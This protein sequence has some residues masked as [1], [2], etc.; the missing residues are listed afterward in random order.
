M[1]FFF[2]V[3]NLTNK[4]KQNKCARKCLFFKLST[5]TQSA[6]IKHQR[7]RHFA[8]YGNQHNVICL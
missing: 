7:W 5:D 8:K 6:V 3:I 1:P 2:S 4:T